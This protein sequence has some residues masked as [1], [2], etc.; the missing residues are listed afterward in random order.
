MIGPQLE[1][2]ATQHPNIKLRRIDVGSWSSPVARQHGIR[3]LPTVWLYENGALVTQ[4]SKAALA[5]LQALR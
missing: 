5:R 2:L 3:R 4:D 1:A